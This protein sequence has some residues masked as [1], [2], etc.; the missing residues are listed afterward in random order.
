M[1]SW[2]EKIKCHNSLVMILCLAVPLIGLVAATYLFNLSKN[3]LLWAVF[4][5]CPL[6]H[7]FMMK[8]MHH[9]K[10]KGEKGGHS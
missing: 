8:D 5:L 3:Y 7:F 4:L 10:C 2:I 1:S 6:M 9:G